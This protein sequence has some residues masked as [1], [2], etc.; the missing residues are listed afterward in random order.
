[1]YNS[2]LGLA[3]GVAGARLRSC[4]SISAYSAAPL[5]I[6]LPTCPA[7]RDRPRRAHRPAGGGALRARA[8]HRWRGLADACAAAAPALVAVVALADLASGTA[9]GMPADLPWA[10]PLWARTATRRRSTN[11]L[12]RC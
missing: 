5:E 9:Y 3:A 2:G 1:V 7:V 4:C 12:P 10:I 11:S 8:P 6:F